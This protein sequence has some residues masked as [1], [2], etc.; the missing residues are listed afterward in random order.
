MSSKPDHGPNAEEHTVQEETTETT[1]E[2]PSENEVTDIQ[3]L[4][5]R[6]RKRAIY[7][8]AFYVPL[9]IIPWILTC[10]IAGPPAT[11]GNDAS[12]FSPQTDKGLLSLLAWV[13]SVRVLNSLASVVT[14][15]V[16]S[17]LLAQAAVVYTQ[18]RLIYQRLSI[19]QTFALAD[20]RWSDIT[21]LIEASRAT[22]NG[23]GSRFLWWG[24]A[25]VVLS[26]NHFS[27]V[28]PS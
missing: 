6:Y 1:P 28:I 25:L 16:T 15:P 21:V 10:L 23:I 9:L 22:G 19:R 3:H 27:T 14:I 5:L 11:N 20:R 18:K 24:M 4:V 26:E 2:Q 8:L 13:G 12:Q 7:L 17:A